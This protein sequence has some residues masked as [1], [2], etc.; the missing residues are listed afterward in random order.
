M[1]VIVV[2]APIV[3]EIPVGMRVPV[4]VIEMV[5]GLIA[6]RTG[7]VGVGALRPGE[8]VTL[9]GQAG[10]GFLFFLVGMEIDVGRFTGRPL[11][12]AVLSWSFSLGLAAVVVTTLYMTPFFR[13]PVM[14]A[15]A[16]TT[17]SSGMLVPILRDAHKLNTSFGNLFM[18]AGTL[19]EFDP[20]C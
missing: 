15:V 8:P 17:T 3:A 18:A 16:L 19:G 2:V 6:V 10:L 11:G 20:I 14:I 13:D 7:F 5:L 1:L 4:V 12:L 9:S